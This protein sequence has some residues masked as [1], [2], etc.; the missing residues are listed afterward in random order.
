MTELKGIAAD[1]PCD[2]V[3]MVVRSS[4]NWS[5]SLAGSCAGWN[6]LHAVQDL[7]KDN[8]PRNL[9]PKGAVSQNFIR[10]LY[11]LPH[12]FSR[13]KDP[14]GEVGLHCNIQQTPR[15]IPRHCVV[16]EI[17]QANTFVE[18]LHVEEHA[19]S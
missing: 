7:A 17:V 5:V 16:D 13:T 19:N 12:Y 9:F 4:T 6:V 10:G 15:K 14:L 11:A 1:G 18:L 8:R 3:D 2:V